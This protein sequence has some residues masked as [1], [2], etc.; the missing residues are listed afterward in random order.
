VG[1]MWEHTRKKNWKKREGAKLTQDLS[2]RAKSI[3]NVYIHTRM[4]H[5]Y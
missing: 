2:I 5:E 1:T 3:A 4:L